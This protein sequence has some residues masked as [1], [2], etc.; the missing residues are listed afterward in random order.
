MYTIYIYRVNRIKF[1]EL[2]LTDERKRQIFFLG[3]DDVDCA[4][5]KFYI[6]VIFPNMNKPYPVNS[7]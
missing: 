6:F 2:G 3:N 1:T 7:V 5:E 4:Y